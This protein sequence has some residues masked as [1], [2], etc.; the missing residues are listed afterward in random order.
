MKRFFLFPGL[1]FL[2][3]LALPAC[4]PPP[5][6]ARESLSSSPDYA[7]G[8]VS[9]LAQGGQGQIYC[10]FGWSK[11]EEKFSWT[12]GQSAGLSLRAPPSGAP[13]TLRMKLAGFTNP[14]GLPAQAVEVSVNGRQIAAW[15]VASTANFF[16]IIPSDVSAS[17]GNLTIVL[18]IPNAASPKALGLNPDGRTLG[19]CCFEMEL[20]KSTS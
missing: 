8:T 16:A 4:K 7:Y 12:E 14:P 15:Q 11:P 5:E 6:A 2:M 18:K 1:R 9:S 10:T 19:I 17:G 20:S 3:L 13:I